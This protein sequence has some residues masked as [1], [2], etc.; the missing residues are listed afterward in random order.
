MDRTHYLRFLVFVLGVFAF[1]L[2][3]LLLG[4][5]LAL[6]VASFI[7]FWVCGALLGKGA[8]RLWRQSL[9]T[10]VS[11]RAVGPSWS[12]RG[13]LP[14]LGRLARVRQ[15]FVLKV[16]ALFKLVLA[17]AAISLPKFLV[18]LLLSLQRPN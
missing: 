14:P 6:L 11:L 12:G 2:L 18:A 1:A 15:P 9:N 16:A 3:A 13:V 4:G 10:S 5:A 8:I 7:V 17:L